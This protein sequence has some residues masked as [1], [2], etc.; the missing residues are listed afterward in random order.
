VLLI[1]IGIVP[2]NFVLYFHQ[3]PPIII[4][5]IAELCRLTAYYFTQNKSHISQISLSHNHQQQTKHNTTQ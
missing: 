4:F 2:R 1:S 3:P 5:E